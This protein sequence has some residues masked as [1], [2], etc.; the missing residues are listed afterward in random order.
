MFQSAGETPP[1]QHRPGSRAHR[2]ASLT[3]KQVSVTRR[4]LTAAAPP[5]EAGRT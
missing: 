5:P 3:Q 2:V 4:R 1:P